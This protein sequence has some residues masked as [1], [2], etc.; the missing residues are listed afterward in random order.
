MR[1]KLLLLTGVALAGGIALYS[2]TQIWVTVSLV[3]GAAAS[4]TLGVTGQQVNQSLS[5]V[6]I[7]ALAAA[8]ALTIAGKVFRRILGV[9]IMLLGAGISAI[10]FAVLRAPEDAIAGRLAEATGIEGAAQAGMIAGVSTSFVVTLTVIAGVL[11]VVLGALVLVFAGRWKAAGR[12]YD[13]NAASKP[14]ANDEPDRISDWEAQNEGF[15]PS[16]ER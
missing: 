5:P 7:A 8:L 13:T 4:D 10:A 14:R 11:L 16:D 15:D 1:S 2:A 3:V 9:L 12:K 6:A